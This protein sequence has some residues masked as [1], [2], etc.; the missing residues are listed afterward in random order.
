PVLEQHV[1][2]KAGDAGADVDALHR[3]DAADESLRLRYGPLLGSDDA[4]GGNGRGLLRLRGQRRA[5][6]GGNAGDQRK[7]F[8]GP[9]A[10]LPRRRKA[11][12]VTAVWRTVAGG[13]LS[14][15]TTLPIPRTLVPEFRRAQRHD[16]QDHASEQERRAD[17]DEAFLDPDEFNDQAH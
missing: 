15:G 7:R 4:D 16:G 10:M 17:D 3:L 13:L 2:E 8:H 11:R 12:T 1:L 6:A 5:Q 9:T 14:P